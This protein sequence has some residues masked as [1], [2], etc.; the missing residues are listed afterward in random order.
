MRDMHVNF[1]YFSNIGNLSVTQR[2][3]LE[4]NLEFV[5]KCLSRAGERRTDEKSAERRDVVLSRRS[6]EREERR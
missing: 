6:W 3:P 5:Y 1:G 4:R 2:L